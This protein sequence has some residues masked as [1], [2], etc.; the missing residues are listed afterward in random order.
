[1]SESAMTEPWVSIDDV[2]EHLKVTK[3][4][5]YRWIESRGLPAHWRFKLSEVDEWVRCGE[6]SE[7]ADAHLKPSS[8]RAAGNAL[9]AP[10]R[11]R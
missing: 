6:S 5:V 7:F 4:S 3:D 1:M 8:S 9:A 11:K 10:G 2:V